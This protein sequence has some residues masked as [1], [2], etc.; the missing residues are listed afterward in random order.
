VAVIVHMDEIANGTVTLK[1]LVSAT[2]ET[3]PEADFVAAVQRM[4]AAA[5]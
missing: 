2:Q 1:N 4:L 5:T 3:V